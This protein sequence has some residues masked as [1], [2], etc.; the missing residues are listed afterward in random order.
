MVNAAMN[1]V[2]GTARVKAMAPSAERSNSV[3]T[4]SLERM[5]RNRNT[6]TLL[7]GL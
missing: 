1:V 4:K 2:M 5:W 3:D 6:Y 7:V